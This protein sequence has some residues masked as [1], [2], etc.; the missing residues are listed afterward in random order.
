MRLSVDSLRSQIEAKIPDAFRFY[1]RDVQE[2]IAT[3]IPEVDRLITGIPVRALTE[4][5]G[6]QMASSGKTSLL[7]SVM[8]RATEKNFCALV[9]A[10]DSFSPESAEA[11]GVDLSRVLWVRCDA[12]ESHF[13]ALRTALKATDMLL[14]AGGF[15]LLVCDLSGI[16]E[17]LV[18]KIPLS[19]WFSFSRAVETM[20]TALV[21]MQSGAYAKSAAALALHV[22]GR[23]SVSRSAAPT[24]TRLFRELKIHVEVTQARRAICGK[25]PAQSASTTFTARAEWA[26]FP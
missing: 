15:R 17:Q 3:G 12:T 26:M 5:C 2:A 7:H 21:V 25:K 24:H 8:A 4:I 23:S 13:R 14:K 11:A 10:T 1:T 18:R 6:S 19:A 16:E 9:D 20:P 22:S